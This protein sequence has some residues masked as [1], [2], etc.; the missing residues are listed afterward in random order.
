MRADIIA[1]VAGLTLALVGGALV[2]GLTGRSRPPVVRDASAALRTVA[3]WPSDSVVDG[4]AARTAEA[5]F[6][7]QGAAGVP[8]M[9]A[10]Y[11]PATIADTSTRCLEPHDPTLQCD[12]HLTTALGAIPSSVTIELPEDADPGCIAAA[13]CVARAYAMHAAPLPSG[14]GQ[15]TLTHTLHLQPGE[16][17]PDN[18][19]RMLTIF[20]EDVATARANGMF[21]AGDPQADFA[22]LREERIIA[23]VEHLLEVGP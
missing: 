10:L 15:V 19:R 6:A 22:V 14:A 1:F 2:Y 17:D 7:E 5:W 4:S 3:V 11:D 20:R 8:T 16:R 23:H 9:L 21:G 18:L 12:Y 13:S